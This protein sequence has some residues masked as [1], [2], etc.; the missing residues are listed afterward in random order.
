MRCLLALWV[1]LS[2]LA[3]V[4]QAQ[5]YPNLSLEPRANYG[6]PL[7]LWSTVVPD[8]GGVTLDSSVHRQG[9][10]SLRLDLPAAPPHRPPRAWLSCALPPDSARGRLVTVSAWVRTQNWRGKLQLSAG[11]TTLTLAGLN[12]E[13][14]SAIDSLPGT[15]DW[16]QLVVQLP[17]KATAFMLGVG[18]RAEG[19]GRVWLDDVQLRVKGHRLPELPAPATEALLLPLAGSLVPNWD[20]EH[21]PPRLTWPDAALARCTLDSLRPQ[22]GR[23]YARLLRT[24][25][26]GQPPPAVY[27]GT[28]PLDPRDGGKILHISGYWRQAVAAGPAGDALSPTGGVP[29]LVPRFAVRLLS[30]GDFAPGQWRADTVG[31]KPAL[32]APG[33]NWTAFAL[34]A[35]MQLFVNKEDEAI[36]LKAMSLAVL[37]PDARPLELDNLTFSI[38]GK[39]YAPTGPPLPPPPSALETGWLRTAL[40]PLRLAA[41]ATAGPDVAALGNYLAPARLVGLGELTHGSREVFALHDQ[42]IRYLVGQKGFNGLLLDADPAGCAA[43]QAYVQTGQGNPARLLAALGDNW[44]VPEMLTL[45]RWLRAYQQAHPAAPLLLAGV[46][47]RRPEQALASLRLLLAPDDDFAQSRLRRLE[48]LLVRFGHPAPNAPDLRRD[49]QQA[50]DSLLAPLRSVLAELNAGLDARAQAGGHPA[51]LVQLAQRR[52]YLRLVE[53]GATWQRIPAPDTAFTYRQAC[54]AENAWYWSQSGTGGSVPRLVLWAGNNAVGRALTLTE[55]PAGEWL[56]ATLGTGYRTLGVVLGRGSFA[57]LSPAGAWV[58]A[59]LAARRP[60]AYEAWLST[61]PPA[62][63]LPLAG[64]E[65]NDDNAWLFQQQLLRDI[66]RRATRNQYQLHCLRDEF[67]AVV[68]LRDSTPTQVLP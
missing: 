23:R 26:A 59:P 55:R 68:Y 19:S 13:S 7:A 4:A 37:L 51:S 41:P 42:L 14:A 43:L 40:K 10:G 44:N 67:D 64:L 32:P 50:S 65:L 12:N 20:L 52:Y 62:S 24:S 30:S 1:V 34:D 35:P 33:P 2:G 57:A 47:V 29:G 38:E 49:P 61:G 25:P 6:H 22:H 5:V 60:G 28:L 46:D 15:T 48:Q 66:D 45:L 11:A 27:L 8:E 3:S 16:H 9:A 31:L 36:T 17:V 53:Q 63:W 58:P 39:P 21:L 56:R 54:L 18:L